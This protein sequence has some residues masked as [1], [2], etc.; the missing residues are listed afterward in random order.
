MKIKMI[1]RIILLLLFL[2]S[3]ICLASCNNSRYYDST[4]Y[5]EIWNLSDIRSEYG[6][7]RNGE[8]FRTVPPIYPS[9]L[10]GRNVVDYLCRYDIRLL[11]A[12][13][14]VFFKVKYSGREELLEEKTRIAG[15]YEN[16]TDKFDIAGSEVYADKMG[17]YVWSYAVINE[18]NNE[19]SYVYIQ[20]VKRG[21]IEFDHSLL[22]EEYPL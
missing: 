6:E 20:Y 7:T 17:E 19:I 2:C 21:D 1:N 10:S 15:G 13:M 16:V 14:Q 5:E 9:T 11:G 4:K 18:E 22:P 3:L 8:F 12:D